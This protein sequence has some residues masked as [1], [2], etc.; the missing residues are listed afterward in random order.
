VNQQARE[1]VWQLGERKPT[2]RFLLRDRDSKFTAAFDSIFASEGIHVIQTPYRSPNANAYAERWVRSVR[3]ECLNK[4][5]IVNEGHLRSVMREYVAYH[6]TARPHQGIAQLT[7]LPRPPT[8][9]AGKVCR[10]EVV[11]GIIGDYYKDTV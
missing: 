1:I 7:P 9:E 8:T 5:L 11:D 3:E 10:R 4:L 2:I 6:N